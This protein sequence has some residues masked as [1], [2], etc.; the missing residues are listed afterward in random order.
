MEILLATYLASDLPRL[1]TLRRGLRD[2]MA[3]SPLCD[4]PAFAR[5]LEAAYRSMWRDWCG[6]QAGGF[7]G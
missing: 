4:G 6:R 2:R 5:K 7:P 1:A 3:A